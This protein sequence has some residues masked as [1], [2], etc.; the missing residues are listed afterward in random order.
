MGDVSRP[1]PQGTTGGGGV[2]V[3]NVNG[4]RRGQGQGREMSLGSN[5]NEREMVTLML[6]NGQGKVALEEVAPSEPNHD[7]NNV[8]SDA[9]CRKCDRMVFKPK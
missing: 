1:E 8:D 5:P 3:L 4:C 6:N 2:V 7:A 9:C